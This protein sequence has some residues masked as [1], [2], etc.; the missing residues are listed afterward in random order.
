ML[1]FLEEFMPHQLSKKFDGTTRMNINLEVEG[2]LYNV[3]DNLKTEINKVENFEREIKICFVCPSRRKVKFDI[4]KILYDN[5]LDNR[6]SNFEVIKRIYKYL[7]FPLYSDKRSKI[8]EKPEQ[9]S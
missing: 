8:L 1:N 4:R 5:L 3:I 7:S 6:S 2:H 9:F